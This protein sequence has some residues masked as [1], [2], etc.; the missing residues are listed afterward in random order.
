MALIICGFTACQLDQLDKRVRNIE[1]SVSTNP[2]T[3]LRIDTVTIG[4]DTVLVEK[5]I[6]AK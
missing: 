5:Y 2:R 1:D 3:L 6:R 4:D